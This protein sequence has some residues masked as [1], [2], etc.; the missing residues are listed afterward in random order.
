MDSENYELFMG[1]WS[2]GLAH[3]FVEFADI[4]PRETTLD[5]GCGTGSLTAALICCH[6]S[7]V[8]CGIEINEDFVVHARRR[9]AG[10]NNVFFVRGDAALMPYP[11]GLFDNTSALL[12]LPFF[13]D[14][15]RV[16][17]EMVRVTRPGGIVSGCSWEPSG[18]EPD[19]MFWDE[20]SQF[21]LLSRSWRQPKRL[22]RRSEFDASIGCHLWSAVGLRNLRFSSLKISMTFESF[23]DFWRPFIN[24]PGRHGTFLAAL[25]AEQRMLMEH[26]LRRRF[27]RTVR[28][29]FQMTGRAFAICGTVPVQLPIVR[30]YSQRFP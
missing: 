9:F 24:S 20:A 22:W 23:E 17:R 16:V 6:K 30:K 8:V 13:A 4:G 11:S 10:K 5:V 25:S 7:D 18:F 28:D 1:R 29:P 12:S 21:Q 26:A 19:A 14:P 2:L 15:L 3:Q 27:S